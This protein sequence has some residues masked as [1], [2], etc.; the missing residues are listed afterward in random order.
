MDCYTIQER[1]L[2][3]FESALPPS[4][5][6]QLERHLSEC[7]ECAQFAT[8]QSQLDFRLQE[9]I[10][11]PSLSPD[12]RQDLQARIAQERQAPWLDWLP[13]VAHLVGSA[14]AIG[15]CT[16]LLPLPAPLILGTGTL[17]ALTA[18][19]LQTLIVS[20]LDPWIE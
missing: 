14:V 5:K 1:V 20:T 9:E 6:E 18:Y 12:F 17:V 10:A 2:E 13:D 8:L 11:P 15:S 16:F 19:S 3:R 7:P 4:E